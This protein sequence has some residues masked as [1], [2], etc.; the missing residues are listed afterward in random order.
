M[1]KT[2]EQDELE[3]LR[4]QVFHNEAY[5]AHLESLLK[6]ESV[7]HILSDAKFRPHYNGMF[8]IEDKSFIE[9]YEIVNKLIEADNADNESREANFHQQLP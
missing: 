6:S 2:F 8:D 9:L 5:I 7:F 3:N 4:H 1:S